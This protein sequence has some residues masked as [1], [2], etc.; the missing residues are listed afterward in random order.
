M[1]MRPSPP[2]IAVVALACRFPDADTPD[3]LWQ[4][5]LDGRRSFRPLPP[6]R[7]PLADYAAG[8]VAGSETIAPVL[9]G[10]LAD[11]QFDRTRFHVPQSAFE[12]ADLAHWLC[13]DVAAEAVGQVGAG[14]L[15][16][17]R[18]GVVVA[19][20]LTGE[21]S[22]A[23]MLRLRLPYLLHRL[24]RGLA[25]READASQRQQAV[26]ALAEA[27]RQDFPDPNEETLAGGLANTIAG[28]IANYFD[29]QGGAWS[30]DGACA[31]SLLAWHDAAAALASGELDAV[32]AGA[33]DL[34]LDPFELIGF[35]RNGALATEE[36]RVFDRRSAGFW[37]GEGAG[38]AVLMRADDAHAR[39]LEP[40]ALL[41][42]WGRST[43]GAGGL[44][45]PSV[46]GQGQALARAYAMAGIDPGA[47]GYVEAHGTG[48][49]VGDPIELRAIAGLLADAGAERSRDPL[50]VGSVKANFGH[51]KAAAG[52]AGMTR[53]IRA[54]RAGLVPPQVGCLEPAA[55]F[56]ETGHR[57]EAPTE[58]REWRRGERFAGV[59][60]FGFGG[61]NVHMALQAAPGTAPAMPAA[62]TVPRPQDAEAFFLA[63]ASAEALAAEAERLAS[64]ARH[65]TLAEMAAAARDTACALDLALPCRAAMLSSRPDWLADKLGAIA[66]AAR[67]GTAPA[68]E[69]VWL[70]TGPAALKPPRIAFLFPGQAAPSRVS[71][72]LWARRFIESRAALAAAAL[73]AAAAIADTT[74]T[75]IAQPAIVAGSLAAWQVLRRCGLEADVAL[76]HSL[77]ELT[78]LAWAG[79][80]AEADLLGL[81]AARGRIVA[82]HAVAGGG[83]LRVAGP[84]AQAE[85]LAARHGLAIACLNGPEDTVLA[86]R[87]EAVAAAQA[88]AAAAGWQASALR[89]SH[90]FHSP[91]M[92]PAAP[93][94]RDALAEFAVSAPARP[95]ISTVTGALL[96]PGDDAKGLLKRQLEAPVRFAAALKTAAADWHIEVGPGAGLTRL[97][98]AAG[99]R[100][101]A[102][103]A[104]G[105]SLH[106]LLAVLAA[107][108]VR[109]VPVR[110]AALYDD[111]PLPAADPWR[112]PALLANPCGRGA[113]GQSPAMPARDIVPADDE[114]AGAHLAATADSAGLL[115]AV[116]AQVAVEAGLPEDAIAGAA[117]LLDDLH[118]NS[119]A[120]GRIVGALTQSLGLPALAAP[121]D[122]AN[123][124]VSG[125]AATL[126][127]LAAA[128][129]SGQM[130]DRFDGVAGWIAPYAFAWEP[131]EPPRIG[132][133]IDWSADGTIATLPP[134]FAPE[135]DALLGLWRTLK[136]AAA[137]GRPHLAI[138]HHGAP[139]FALARTLFE[140]KLFDTVLLID[141]GSG[142]ARAPLLAAPPRGFSA[143]RIDAA[144][145]LFRPVFQRVEPQPRPGAVAAGPADV[146]LVTGGGRGIGAEC[147]LALARHTG[148]GVLLVGRSAP[149]RPEVAA[150]LTRA[151]A[152]GLRARYT[153]ADGTDAAA[154]AAAVASVADWGPVTGLVHAAGLNRPAGFRDLD[155]TELLATLAPKLDGLRAAL[156]A[157]G[158][159]NLRWIVTFGSI[160]GRLGLAGEAHYALAN[161]AQSDLLQ[162]LAPPGARAH[163]LEWSVWAG[164]GMGERLG[165][166][167]HLAAKGVAALSLDDALAAFVGQ[168]TVP[169]LPDGPVVLTGRFGPPEGVQ[170]GG[171]PPNL[172]YLD[173]VRVFFPGQEIVADSTLRPATDP[174]LPDHMV[175]GLA[176]VPGALLLEAMRQAAAALGLE[177]GTALRIEDVTFEAAVTVGDGPPTGMR[178]AA[179]R[180]ED[181]SIA[182]VIRSSGDGFQ[183]ACARAVFRAD[184]GPRALAALPSVPVPRAVAAAPVYDS[185]LFQ[186]G[187]FRRLAGYRHLAATALSA[188]LLPAPA[189]P[190]FGG[191]LSGELLLGDPGARD[192]GLHALQA[193]VPHQRVLPV[194]VAHI[195]V[196]APRAEPASV[197]AWEVSSDGCTYV[198]E[199]VWRDAAGRA[200]EHWHKAAFRSIAS[201]NPAALPAVLLPVYI[202]RAVANALGRDGGFA[203]ALGTG[204][205]ADTLAPLGI[206]ERLH[207]GDGKPILIGRPGRNLSLA[208]SEDLVFAVTG[209]GRLACDLEPLTARPW[210]ADGVNGDARLI[211]AAAVAWEEPVER[212]ALRV[213]CARECL[214][215]AGFPPHEPLTLAAGS[216]GSPVFLAGQ[217]RVVTLPLA[218]HMT[219]ILADPVP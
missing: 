77:G 101:H 179:L 125:L 103:D 122:H 33:V 75:D 199:I 111:R 132:L 164:A 131:A 189:Q 94:F 11:W 54:L 10:L 172:R 123:A 7:L 204:G 86:G 24:D 152:E 198:F 35:S 73:P 28:R 214:R 66:D 139:V 203:A 195:A 12:A 27:L 93:V 60:G 115:A 70:Q 57:L 72:G 25:A 145:R 88:T 200:V 171:E 127:E 217:S 154:L 90:A 52:F 62:I 43:D 206:D 78:A 148:V 196:A 142:A 45:R 160:I 114:Q 102:I 15:P 63:A 20:T 118:L 91:D 18:T 219:A 9:A 194:S 3:Q 22:R 212:A 124:T 58:A 128:G 4:N 39:G 30:V 176:V 186:R 210:G 50:P 61:I 105:T 120:V 133:R 187:R 21:F 112:K 215:K 168:L 185:L 1:S 140:E 166:L 207:R 100:A 113:N 36:M 80:I 162:R 76:G 141:G 163:A 167:E 44:T 129:V 183:R 79:A 98:Q 116:R 173:R 137:S 13:L 159:H 42:G 38:A 40:L 136:A 17:E 165:T 32:V 95:V 82:A 147:G 16:A 87:P 177:P 192:A 121:T 201:L 135:T 67:S 14:R 156:A 182:A 49:A 5:M 26:E 53:A 157:C 109:G 51:T 161:A 149:D 190:W 46:R 110:P 155:E 37:P 181:G 193:S 74:A 216:D 92:A 23:Q 56:A 106:G 151:A 191:F 211:E 188:D 48:T 65:W 180:R 8:Q 96:A 34:S 41:R 83:M 170:L 99:Y 146:F 81:A 55:V 213:W 85:A 175:D 143:W 208:D 134:D 108:F 59:S 153:Q 130:P 119:L 89:V 126:R 150:T 117:H 218:T 184:T 97:A 209:S 64:H 174:Y 6:E 47:L 71:G 138:L 19:N 197:E 68:G 202:E 205:K 29:L 144:D 107:A 104:H 69:G 2:P 169:N 158:P 31:S 178:V 84:P